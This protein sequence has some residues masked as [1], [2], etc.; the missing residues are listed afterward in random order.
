MAIIST[1]ASTPWKPFNAADPSVINQERLSTVTGVLGSTIPISAGKRAVPGSC[2]WA[3]QQATNPLLGFVGVVVN[4]NG[5]QNTIASSWRRSFAMAFGYPL[6]PFASRTTINVS[7]I[8]S[9]TQLIY[10]ATNKAPWF[11]PGLIEIAGGGTALG[12]YNPAAVQFVQFPF[13]VYDGSTLTGPDPIISADKGDLTPG[14]HNMIYIV[15]PNFPTGLISGTGDVPALQV[16]F[17]DNSPPLNLLTHF[18][19]LG[20]SLSDSLG[21]VG[22]FSHG[23][24]WVPDAYTTSAAVLREFSITGQVEVARIPITGNIFTDLTYTTSNPYTEMDSLADEATYDFGNHLVFLGGEIVT[25]TRPVISISLTTGK[26]VDQFGAA[27]TNTAPTTLGTGYGAVPDVQ[28]GCLTSGVYA[29]TPYRVFVAQSLL[30]KWITLL[31]YNAN[32]TFKADH[33]NG[34]PIASVGQPDNTPA[35]STTNG[36]NYLLGYPLTPPSALIPGFIT[37]SFTDPKQYQDFAILVANNS[38]LE[39]WYGG[40][41]SSGFSTF[42]GSQNI[43]DFGS[44][45]TISFILVDDTDGDIVVVWSTIVSLVQTWFATKFPVTVGAGPS[46]FLGNFP[47]IGTAPIWSTTLTPGAGTAVGFAQGFRNAALTSRLHGSFGYGGGDDVASS[48]VRLNLSNGLT[49]TAVAGNHPPTGDW[50]W[51]GATGVFY[52]A[53]ATAHTVDSTIMNFIQPNG[54]L[55]LSDV[56]TWMAIL[57]GYPSGKVSVDTSLSSTSIE[58]VLIAQPWSPADL[59]NNMGKAY[60]FTWFFSDG[61]LKFTRTAQSLSGLPPVAPAYSITKDDMAPVGEGG[62]QGN[63]VLAT[64]LQPPLAQATGIVL[65]YIQD[66]TYTVAN[67]SYQPDTN[68]NP[69]MH[70]VG[71]TIPGSFSNT[72]TTVNLPIVM[73]PDTAYELA[74]TASLAANQQTVAQEL[75]L[76]Q[77]FSLMEPGDVLTATVNGFSYNIK[78][79]EVTFNTDWSISYL[80]YNY[81]FNDQLFT[82]PA[83][84]NNTLPQTLPGQSDSSPVALDMPLISPATL[85]ADGI[86]VNWVGAASWGQP[87]W[88]GAS[89]IF[90]DNSGASTVEHA[91]AATV[92]GTIYTALPTCPNPWVTDTTTTIQ[93][94]M[95]G[96][97]AAKF[98]STNNAGLLSGLNM[99]VIGAPGRWE[100]INFQNVTVV[101]DNVVVLDT[102]IRGRRG[103]D[104]HTDDHAA[105]DSFFLLR[106]AATGFVPPIVPQALPAAD[107]G[108][109][110]TYQAV[111]D[112]IQSAVQSLTFTEAGFSAYPFTVGDPEAVQS[113]SDIILTWHRRDRGTTNEWVTDPVLMSEASL[114]FDVEVYGSGAFSTLKRTFSGLTSETVTYTAAQQAT[115]GF[116]APIATLYTKIYQRSAVTGRGFAKDLTLPTV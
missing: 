18:T 11:I 83:G 24:L 105:G 76:P 10:D 33:T 93:V 54:S 59:F 32:G 91:T 116:S 88:A 62:A 6:Q 38:R 42:K 36:L 87:Q 37:G 43:H 55:A 106:S 12:R 61:A 27:S 51:D 13:T 48:L 16:E 90:K 21:I 8:W 68:L 52:S 57:A 71:F 64:T 3:A 109:A 89:V 58:G 63:E 29:N 20:T 50:V 74:V 79:D 47:T 103:T 60:G 95:P 84:N 82:N 46:G 26:I 104:V 53:D 77:G 41:G 35:N 97:L 49:T 39:L 22:D 98:A 94:V 72:S 107:I 102:L 112:S 30:N 5:Q 70:I 111:G 73:A 92:S 40:Q 85:P 1:L 115:D 69:A 86:L 65:G 75:R 80:G 101:N 114:L 31:D 96:A 99:C 110:V 67:A 56:L 17:V 19:P 113:G 14:F 4:S 100:L 2:I 81:N 45:A 78:L 34:I 15:F 23:V 66:I 108:E 9:G 25:N 7:R 44:T 28:G